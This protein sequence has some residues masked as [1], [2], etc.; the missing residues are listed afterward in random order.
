MIRLRGSKT[1]KVFNPRLINGKLPIDFW[2][3]Q[4]FL[5]AFL[6]LNNGQ[7]VRYLLPKGFFAISQREG[8]AAPFL[9]CIGKAG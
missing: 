1:L 9:R 2:L 4:S 7:G 6:V 8:V 3:S 5:R